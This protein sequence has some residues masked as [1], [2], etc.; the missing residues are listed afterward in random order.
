[1]TDKEC[2]RHI[3]EIQAAIATIQRCAVSL[4]DIGAAFAALGRSLSA[5]LDA[6]GVVIEDVEPHGNSWEPPHANC[7]CMESD[8]TEKGME[9]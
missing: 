5:A 7:R 1:M 3:Q 6:A 9:K 8:A 4:A 2:E